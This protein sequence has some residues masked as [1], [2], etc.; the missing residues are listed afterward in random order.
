MLVKHTKPVME[1]TS[2]SC[3]I[4]SN[5]TPGSLATLKAFI[6]TL[7]NDRFKDT[8]PEPKKLFLLGSWNLMKGLPF[9]FVTN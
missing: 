8:K 5:L 7:K 9:P 2:T 1:S 4:M 3:Q 6:R